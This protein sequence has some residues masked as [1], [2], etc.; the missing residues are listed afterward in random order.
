MHTVSFELVRRAAT[1][2]LRGWDNGILVGGWV[3]GGMFESVGP[4]WPCQWCW[5]MRRDGCWLADSIIVWSLSALAAWVHL[6]LL[7]WLP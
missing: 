6:W 4:V 5:V 2:A 7:G 3:R 1:I